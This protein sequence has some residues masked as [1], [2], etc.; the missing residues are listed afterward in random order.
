ME[1]KIFIRCRLWVAHDS[2]AL[3]CLEGFLN[4]ICSDCYLLVAVG[5]ER[6]LAILG[7]I[8]LLIDAERVHPV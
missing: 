4:G 7:I 3:N 5:L 1:V 6:D 8:G 2:A